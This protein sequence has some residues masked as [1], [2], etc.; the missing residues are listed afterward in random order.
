MV[1]RGFLKLDAGNKKDMEYVIS[2]KRGSW[3]LY[4]GVIEIELE[5]EQKVIV[6]LPISIREP[7]R[8]K[9]QN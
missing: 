7:L 1:F 8:L 3:D 6:I 4:D 5:N 9:M 2:L